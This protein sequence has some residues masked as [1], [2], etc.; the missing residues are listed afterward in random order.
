MA[1]T[2]TPAARHP[3]RKT[4]R[5]LFLFRLCLMAAAT[6]FFLE[7]FLRIFV[8]FPPSHVW[9]PG[10]DLKRETRDLIDPGKRSSYHFRTNSFGTRGREPA[11]GQDA[12]LFLG[13]ST[14]EGEGISDEDTWP[15]VATAALYPDPAHRPAC[16]NGSRSG[17]LLSHNLLHFE[18]LSADIR[19]G[20]H[21]IKAVVVMP[22]AG[23][24][25]TFLASPRAPEAVGGM[26]SVRLA[27]LHEQ[28]FPG[29]ERY[30]NPPWY[31]RNLAWLQISRLK[32]RLVRSDK[33]QR[34]SLD[35]HGKREI[36][37]RA[38]LVP[39]PPEKQAAFPAFLAAY[40][41]DLD[42]LAARCARLG[43]PLVIV[44][45]PMALAPSLASRWNSGILD[46]R[47]D[48]VTDA[49]LKAGSVRFLRDADYAA[50]LN[51]VDSTARAA[52]LACATCGTVGL[53][54]GLNLDPEA[55]YDTFHFTPEGCRRAGAFVARDFPMR[56][57]EAGKGGDGP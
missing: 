10:M 49:A 46:A 33:D 20:G 44:E 28:A 13:S 4:I 45:Q 15:E 26:D 11:S 14:M 36:R 5:G 24:V 51:S 25:Q 55:F 38:V 34:K 56:L 32:A 53:A 16:M 22:G 18:S 12:L 21:A 39:L 42:S 30:A 48:T 8:G 57:L 3:D 41:R 47:I 7:G 17:M 6:P 29:S 37:N 1:E 2:E 19:A 23:D 50:L 52:A 9:I 43:V 54:E 31:K 40:R 35:H 27:E